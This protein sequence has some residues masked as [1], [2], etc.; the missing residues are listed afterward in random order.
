MP[1]SLSRPLVG[2]ASEEVGIP[3]AALLALAA[4][5][6]DEGLDPHALLVA[7]AGDVVLSLIHI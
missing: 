2:R 5:L 7:R 4:R 1:A 6:Q 3:S